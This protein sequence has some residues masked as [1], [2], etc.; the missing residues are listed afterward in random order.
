MT[1]DEQQREQDVLDAASALIIAQ[2]YDK[3]TMSDVAD[4]V[5]LSRGLVYL[6]FK[7]K[8]DLLES[9]IQRELIRYRT[10]W[11][12][13]LETDPQGGTVASVY[14]SVLYALKNTPLLHAIVARDPATF[15]KYLRK[16]GNAFQSLQSTTLTTNFLQG[17][18]SAGVIRDDVNIGAMAYIMDNFS[19][20]LM[21]LDDRQA[22][23]DE[24]IETFAGMLDRTLTPEDG[25]NL[26]AGKDYLRQM[27]AETQHLFNQQKDTST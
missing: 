13:Y 14:R 12:E 17:M 10:L 5:G 7:S 26:E 20:S 27:I 23:Y 22:S 3:T 1:V 18:K 4:A 24:L 21:Q 9:L 15:G 16:S 25:G 6:C 2:G 8:D 19:A 11:V